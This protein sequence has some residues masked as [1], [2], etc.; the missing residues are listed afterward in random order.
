MTST[1]YFWNKP[2]HS[3]IVIIEM[4]PLTANISDKP[5]AKMCQRYRDMHSLKFFLLDS[6]CVQPLGMRSGYI[7]ESQFLSSSFFKT[8]QDS[9]GHSPHRARL[10]SSGHWSPADGSASIDR[11][12][13]ILI[14]FERF[15]RLKMVCLSTF[16][17]AK[18]LKQRFMCVVVTF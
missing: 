14:N 2:P 1:H 5:I 11:E 4:K 9:L 16:Y 18:L 10:G 13:F 17:C 3:E 12:Q 15:I 6:P 8:S 7:K